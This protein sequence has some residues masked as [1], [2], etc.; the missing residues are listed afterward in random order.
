M[1][2]FADQFLFELLKSLTISPLNIIALLGKV[3]K[4][5]IQLVEMALMAPSF[6]CRYSKARSFDLDGQSQS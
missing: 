3:A 5:L 6:F 1:S 2:W 4:L